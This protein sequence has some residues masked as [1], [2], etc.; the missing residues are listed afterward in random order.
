MIYAPIMTNYQ[1]KYQLRICEKSSPQFR[2][3]NSVKE[4]ETLPISIKNDDILRIVRGITTNVLFVMAKY[5][6]YR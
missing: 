2:H 4:F 6:S 5:E 1:L 3:V